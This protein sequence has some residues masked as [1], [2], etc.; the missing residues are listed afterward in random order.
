MFVTVL[1][2]DDNVINISE[3]VVAD[4]V[5]HNRFCHPKKGGARVLKAFGHTYKEVDARGCYKAY[6]GLVFLFH[7]D[8]VVT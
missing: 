7:V 2:S 3:N 4:M 8:L 5:F 1:A 6:L